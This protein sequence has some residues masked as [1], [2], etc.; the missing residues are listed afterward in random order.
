MQAN[1]LAVFLVSGRAPGDC[2]WCK[3]S[4]VLPSSPESERPNSCILSQSFWTRATCRAAIS[5]LCLGHRCAGKHESSKDLSQKSVPSRTHS[6]VC[7]LLAKEDS[8][9]RVRDLLLQIEGIVKLLHRQGT[10]LIPL[11]SSRSKSL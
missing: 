10:A 7:T 8:Y 11:L 5:T 9:L 2:R 6:A 1:D 3:E 4:N